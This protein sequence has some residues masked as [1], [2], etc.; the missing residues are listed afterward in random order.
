MTARLEISGATVTFG[1]RAAL[2][3]FD[4]AVAPGEVVA[5]LGPS[6][7]GKSTLLRAVAGLQHLDAGS[8]AIDGVD[9]AAV[10]A[11]RRGVG[12]MFQEHALFPHRDVAGNVGFGLRMQSRPAA[13]IDR[14]VEE[15]LRLVDLPGFGPRRVDTLS[16]GERQRVA[17]ARALAPEPR[18]LLLDEPL[19]ALDQ[20][21]RERLVAE[22]AGLFR[23]LDLTVLAVTH[24][25]GEAFTLADRV[26]LTDEGRQLQVGTPAELWRAP[27]DR[28]AA[29]LLGFANVAEVSVAAGV[30]HTPWGPA[31]V[32]APDGDGEA[33]VR[34]SDV[35]LVADGPG[36]GTVIA[37]AFRGTHTALVL[38]VP[39][40][41]PLEVDLTGTGPEVGQM[42][43]FRLTGAVLLRPP[44]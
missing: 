3:R 39:G 33:V 41:P 7:S 20:A 26:L 23:R 28:R 8:I 27:G 43:H 18:I 9:Q 1:G 6:G 42:V 32:D 16:G 12:L 30:A 11:H 5:V 36:R 37:S 24:D 19:G 15:L 21:L 29:T 34:E 2:D 22:L 25:R 17:L 40:A 4:L 31:P 35:E 10:P 44:G 38:E 14:R 13:E